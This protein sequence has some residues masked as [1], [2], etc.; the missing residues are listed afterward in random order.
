MGET[1]PSINSRWIFGFKRGVSKWDFKKKRK[2]ENLK[3]SNPKSKKGTGSLDAVKKYYI[4]IQGKSCAAIWKE[5]NAVQE[6][7]FTAQ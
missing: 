2:K 6:G 4:K 1:N 7:H 5:N 3:R